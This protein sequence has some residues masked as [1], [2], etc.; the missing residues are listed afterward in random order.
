MSNADALRGFL[1]LASAVAL[2]AVVWMQRRERVRADLAPHEIQYLDC[3]ERVRGLKWRV[4]SMD[5]NG[6]IKRC[7]NHL[8]HRP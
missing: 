2:T 6:E 1:S 4:L 5:G 7:L 3:L 8:A